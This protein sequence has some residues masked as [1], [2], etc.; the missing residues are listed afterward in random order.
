MSNIDRCYSEKMERNSR[1]VLSL[2]IDELIAINRLS[3]TFVL[4]DREMIRKRN[5]SNWYISETYFV[6]PHFSYFLDQEFPYIE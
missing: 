2:M 4:L 1:N 5:I 6:S 3:L